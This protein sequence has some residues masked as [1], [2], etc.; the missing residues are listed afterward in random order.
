ML[1][2]KPPNALCNLTCA[3]RPACV[4]CPIALKQV[5]RWTL[6]KALRVILRII[7]EK[8]D[9]YNS[10]VELPGAPRHHEAATARILGPAR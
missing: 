10:Y 6:W 4:S 9:Y 7:T 1:R 5:A 3:A 8:N 2:E